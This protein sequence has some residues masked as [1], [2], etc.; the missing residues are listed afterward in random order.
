M[1]ELK[2]ISKSYGEHMVL[3]DLNLSIEKGSITSFIGAN[4][5]GKSTL[6]SI[7]ARLIR[8]NEGDIYI[9]GEDIAKIKDKDMAKRL[10]FLKQ[11]NFINI[12]LTIRELVAFGRFPHS[13]GRLSKE[14]NGAIDEA[15]DFLALADIQH[16]YL[17]QISGGQRQRAFIAMVVAQNTDYILLDEPL[18]NLD[19]K[20]SVQIM[21]VLKSLSND[22][23]KTIILVMHDIN[24][25]SCYSDN[26]V[27]LRDGKIV[28]CGKTGDIIERACLKEIFDMDFD[29]HDIND[30]KFCVYFQ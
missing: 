3:D 5:A 23:G 2:D 22:M 29:V 13:R 27:A 26:I 17:D 25:A 18:N 4:G 19:M 12:K 7:I 30:C 24:F 11:S 15:L 1:L 6:L 8:Q 20:H 9:E 10:S 21:K 28:K 14:D 16:K